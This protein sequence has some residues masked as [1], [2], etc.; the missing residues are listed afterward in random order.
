MQIVKPLAL[1]GGENPHGI[2]IDAVNHLAFV[3]CEGNAKLFLVD[4]MVMKVL[5]SYPVGDDPDVLAFDPGL[6]ILNVSAESGEVRVFRE[7]E[8]KLEP[9][10]GFDEPHAPYGIC[11]ST[12]TFGVLS[13]REC[14]R[15]S[16]ASDYET[17]AIQLIVDETN[18]R[19]SGTINA[20]K[21]KI[22]THSEFTLSELGA[23]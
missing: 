2:A 23:F 6:G 21:Y 14:Q 15:P 17:Q 18:I 12:Y 7:I 1:P 20:A 19:S 3:A 8:R 16:L 5:A 11:R 9:I 13:P 4:L 22:R 10:G